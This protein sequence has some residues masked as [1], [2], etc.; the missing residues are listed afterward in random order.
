MYLCTINNEI[1]KIKMI[2]IEKAIG[3]F[4]QL[5]SNGWSV[6]LALE[7]CHDTVYDT[8]S[9]KA[10]GEKCLRA[11]DLARIADLNHN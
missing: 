3:N 9:L 1:N 11:V 5:V 8:I 7:C 10:F 4:L 2:T 6:Q